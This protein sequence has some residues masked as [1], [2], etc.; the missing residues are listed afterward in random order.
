VSFRYLR[1]GL[2]G[3][4][5]VI[6]LKMLLAPWVKVPTILSLGVV[7]VIVALAMFCSILAARREKKQVN[8]PDSSS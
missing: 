4:L 5:V 1:T 7:V 2:A 6:G 8:K 3:V